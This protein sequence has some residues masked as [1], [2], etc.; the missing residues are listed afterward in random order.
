MK[1]IMMMN[2]MMIIQ[3][4]IRYK[5]KQSQKKKPSPNI[6]YISLPYIDEILTRKVNAAIKSSDLDIRVAWKSG[7]TL[8][9]QLTSSALQT[10]DCPRGCRKTCLTVVRQYV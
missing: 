8:S 10:P 7:P 2:M 6:T 1:M 9:N 5:N 3:H 4:A